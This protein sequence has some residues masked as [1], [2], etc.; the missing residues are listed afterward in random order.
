MPIRVLM[1]PRALSHQ[2]RQSLGASTQT[3]FGLLGMILVAG[4]TTAVTAT[5][6][7]VYQHNQRA[8]QVSASTQTAR[9]LSQRVLSS[10]ASAPNFAGLSTAAALRDGVFTKGDLSRGQPTHTWGGAIEVAPVNLPTATGPGN[11][12]GFAITYDQVPDSSCTHLVA[13]AGQ[14]FY[15]VRVNNQSVMNQ[16]VVSV[17]TATA[18]CAQ[19]KTAT[20]QFIQAKASPQGAQQPELTPCVVAPSENRQQDCP[21]GQISSVSPYNKDG[22]TQH[23]DAFCNSAYGQM[24]WTPWQTTV[25][26]C[27]PICTPPAPIAT[28]QPL[29]GTCPAGQYVANTT[30]TTFPQ[31]QVGTIGYTCPAPT[32]P[33][34]TNAPVWGAISPLAPSVCAPICSAPAPTGNSGS[35]TAAC[36]GGQVTSSGSTSFTQTRTGTTSYSCPSPTG[37]YTTNPTAWNAWTPAVGSVCAPQCVAPGPTSARETQWVGVN[38]GCPSGWTGSHTYEKEQARTNTTSYK[39]PSPQGGYTANPT[40]YGGWGDTG[41]TRNDSNSCTQPANRA[42][43]QT[44]AGCGYNTYSSGGVGATGACTSSSGAVTWVTDSNF[45]NAWDA[46]WD[47]GLGGRQVCT[48]SELLNKYFYGRDNGCAESVRTPWPPASC[49]VPGQKYYYAEVSTRLDCGQSGQIQD[50]GTDDSQNYTVFVCQ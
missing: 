24:G 33:Y 43:V 20:V 6:V 3:G 39:C 29:T 9:A 26:T 23:H 37:P 7:V 16:R 13:S 46:G 25:N 10:Y 47:A 12:N 5:A 32:G 22:I 40:A 35:Q 49:S 14:G 42:F 44:P 48:Q 18:L 31:T 17:P 2:I 8:S 27:A 30:N 4:L 28:S 50:C 19:Q 38:A 34:T 1:K 36:P 11:D 45:W 41:A 15:D 21:A